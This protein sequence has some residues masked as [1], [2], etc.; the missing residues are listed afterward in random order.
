[1]NNVVY[2]TIKNY[3]EVDNMKDKKTFA[4]ALVVLTAFVA[5]SHIVVKAVKNK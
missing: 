5:T 2:V 1:M 4:I 3:K